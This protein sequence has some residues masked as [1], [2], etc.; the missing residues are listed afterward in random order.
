MII[1]KEKITTMQDTEKK[2]K[3]RAVK[4]NGIG[5]C[6][7]NNIDF[8]IHNIEKY[9]GPD[10]DLYVDGVKVENP[11]QYLEDLK[12]EE[13]KTLE[14]KLVHMC[15]ELD[16]LKEENKRLKKFEITEDEIRLLKGLVFQEV[17]DI[18]VHESEYDISET[19]IGN[20]INRLKAL[21]VKLESMEGTCTQEQK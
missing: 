11:T 1:K 15:Y 13:P 14:D 2:W 17:G 9:C 19:S 7:G 8:L 4:K 20:H 5:E 12:Q 16:N 18:V 6:F 10:F 3:Y 21:M